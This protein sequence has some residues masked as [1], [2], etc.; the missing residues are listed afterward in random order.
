[1]YFKSKNLKVKLSQ[2][3][4]KHKIQFIISEDGIEIGS[5]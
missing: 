5:R 2:R 1:M 3:L 4:P